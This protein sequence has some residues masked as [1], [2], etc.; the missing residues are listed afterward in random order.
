MLPSHVKDDNKPDSDSALVSRIAAGEQAAFEQLMRRYNRTLYRTAR[1]I[2]KDDTEAEDALQEA[3]ML[4]YR[5]L[6][7]FRGDAKLS[8]WL[9]R[10]VVNEAIARRR[11]TTRMAEIIRLDGDMERGQQGSETTMDDSQIEQPEAAAMR[12][13]LTGNENRRT[14]RSIS[15]GVCA[16]GAGRDDRGGS[17]RGSR[18]PGSNGAHTSLP[19]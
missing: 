7:K 16:A 13:S 4:A 9:T 3:Y 18:H 10:I 14:P 19:R 15:H 2:L 8:T 1:S 5:S 17:Q 12:A 6:T 11:K